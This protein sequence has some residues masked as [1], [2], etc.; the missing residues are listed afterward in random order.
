M[1]RLCYVVVLAL[2]I[3]LFQARPAAADPKSEYFD[4]LF[5]QTVDQPQWKSEIT[6]CEKFLQAS[7]PI[8]KKGWQQEIDAAISKKRVEEMK[9]IILLVDDPDLLKMS[10][11][12]SSIILM[13][14]WKTG[15]P[16]LPYVDPNL[17]RYGNTVGSLV[18]T[19]PTKDLKAYREDLPDKALENVR[20]HYHDGLTATSS[21][22]D[23]NYPE[24]KQLMDLLIFYRTD[25]YSRLSGQTL[26]L[27]VTSGRAGMYHLYHEIYLK[28]AHSKPHTAEAVKP[29]RVETATQEP[30]H[31]STTATTEQ[32][33]SSPSH[34]KADEATLFTGM[35]GKKV[36]SFCAT[37]AKLPYEQIEY[38]Y[39]LVGKV[40]M[41]Y[42]A[43]TKADGPKLYYDDVANDP[44]S[45]TQV[46]WFQKGTYIY[47]L[48]QCGGGNC[49]TS[50]PFLVVFNGKK[51][52]LES[53]CQVESECEFLFP[54]TSDSSGPKS[55]S[56]IIAIKDA[57]SQLGL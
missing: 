3:L 23:A 46:M 49:E 6:R 30:N 27:A 34:C 25:D 35:F 41:T 15:D 26:S 28:L 8:F 19:Y 11:V 55:L 36:L 7:L 51:K 14:N 1:S 31:K 45:S 54:V 32:K 4:Y 56:P 37:P 22:S 12:A 10:C 38:R 2:T 43:T 48:L 13:F 9:G 5:S 52:L 29:A 57:P 44:R 21:M 20:K 18:W 24:I 50:K 33:L 53:K 40:D 47:V 39:G 16:V 42:T 17:G